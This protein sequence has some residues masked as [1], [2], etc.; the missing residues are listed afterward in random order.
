MIQQNTPAMRRV[1]A[2]AT[3]LNEQY[4]YQCLSGRAD[5]AADRCP[6]VERASRAQITCEDLRPD[7]RWVRVP[8]VTWPHIFGRPCLDIAAP[9]RE[10]AA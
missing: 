8:D 7:L 10:E 9:A 2:D 3:G 5:L 4:L 6:D 1:I